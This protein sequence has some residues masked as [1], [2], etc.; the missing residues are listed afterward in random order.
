LF[1]EDQARR[2]AAIRPFAIEPIKTLIGRHSRYQWLV[3]G[4]FAQ[5]NLA[6]FGRYAIDCALSDKLEIPGTSREELVRVRSSTPN[7]EL[8]V[9][10]RE[11]QRE[12]WNLFFVAMWAEFEAAIDDIR[13]ELLRN[14]GTL[15]GELFGVQPD[16][17]NV[18]RV[19]RAL[20]GKCGE[21]DLPKFL[22]DL[23]SYQLLGF[24]PIAAETLDTLAEANA[25]RNV[26]VHRRGVIDLRAIQESE[27]LRQRASPILLDA[28]DYMRF[29]SA[30]WS[31]AQGYLGDLIAYDKTHSVVRKEG[32]NSN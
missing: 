4:T 16:F 18:E 17:A 7:H 11:H 20:R 5:L 22:L 19:C 32:E 26:L 10:N 13:V 14:T 27:N 23:K 24:S 2:L 21:K 1:A 15:A 25:I 31:W 29:W 30:S 28:D 9:K 3:L 8:I 12:L 6:H